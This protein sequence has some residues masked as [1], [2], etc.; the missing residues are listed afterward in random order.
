MTRT[1]KLRYE[2]TVGFAEVLAE[3]RWRQWRLIRSAYKR[4]VAGMAQ[5]ELYGE[6]RAQ[7]VGQGLH[8]WLILSGVK[9]ASAL[10]A[11]HPGGRI[12]FGGRRSFLDRA[13]GRIGREEWRKVRLPP[14]Y[15]EG[16]ARSYGAQGGNHLVTLDMARDRVLYHGPEG[17]DFPIKLCLSRKS[18]EYR[19]RLA[20]L[21]ACCETVRDLPFTVSI[22][23][24][25]IALAWR[26]PPA[27][28][29]CGIKGRVLALDLNP[30]KLGWAVVEDGG[31]GQ[32]SCRCVACGMFEYPDL[33]K[34]LGLAADDPPSLAH[35]F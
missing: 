24:T 21:Q 14:L 12:V 15:I 9:K 11:R 32:G 23:E 5:R 35:N 18:R 25:E 17:R 3:Q 1:I 28:P 30:A 31:A 33:A 16:H 8:T 29:S 4:L 10:Y 22:T 20:E 27:P 13:Q 19:R 7:P 6:L 2:P 34:R 26:E